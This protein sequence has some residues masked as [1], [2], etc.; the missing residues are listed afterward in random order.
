[1]DADTRILPNARG[2]RLYDLAEVLRSKNAGP[3]L[4]TFD[5]IL[6]DA[7]TYRRVVESEVLTPELIGRLYD[8]P[9]ADVQIMAFEAANAIKITIPRTGPTSGA[10]GDRDVYGA[11]QHV[12]LIDILIP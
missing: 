5:V 8:L 10:P 1:M 9:P 4:I 2:E 6:P 7:A 11:Q 3:L 12:P